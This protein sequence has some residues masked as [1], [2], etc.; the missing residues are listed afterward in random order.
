M[1]H[2][3]AQ[4]KILEFREEGPGAQ[5]RL[6]GEAVLEQVF[7]E[8]GGYWV[9]EGKKQRHLWR[10]RSYRATWIV[11]APSACSKHHPSTCLSF[12]AGT[13]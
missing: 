10:F 9:W 11:S 6:L 8:V 2:N 13:H 3:E 7:W 5:G 4:N 12:P 1:V